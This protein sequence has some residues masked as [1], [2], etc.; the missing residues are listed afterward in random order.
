MLFIKR[1]TPE[2]AVWEAPKYTQ[3]GARQC[4]AIDNIYWLEDFP[5]IFHSL[6]RKVDYLYLYADD[7]IGSGCGQL[8]PEQSLLDHVTAAGR[9]GIRER[10]GFG[11][12]QR[13]SSRGSRFVRSLLYAGGTGLGPGVSD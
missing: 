6:M 9:N 4:S 10:C 12:G 8:R 11:A 2:I 3:E 13:I 7:W 1:S 5:A